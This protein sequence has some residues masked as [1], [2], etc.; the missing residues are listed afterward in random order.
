MET[1]RWDLLSAELPIGVRIT[2]RLAM[3]NRR[4]DVFIGIDAAG[5]RHVLIEIPAGEPQALIERASR[6]I[7]VQ[8]VSMK[9]ASDGSLCDFV[10]IV[11]IDASGHGALDLVATE[12]ADVLDSGAEPSRIEVVQNILARWRRFW[13]DAGPGLLSYQSQLGL[14]GELWF[15]SRWVGPSVGFARGV[16]VWRG[17]LGAR[18]DFEFAGAGFEV[19]TSARADGVHVVNGLEQLIE[20]ADGALFLLS[21]S[22]RDEATAEDS[23]PALVRALR[24]ALAHDFAHLS[25][26]DAVLYASGYRDEMEH[27]YKK[28]KF[29]VRAE[30]LYRVTAEFPRIV[31]ESFRDVLPPG[32]G[33]VT[34]ELDLECANSWLVARSPQAAQEVLKDFLR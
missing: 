9:I 30:R 27:E 8:V 19:K 15:L 4:R 24:V 6:G 33:N 21:V 22:V 12:I 5:R 1:I 10:D 28:V 34:Y 2:V 11:C 13:A 17:P 32:I 14:F 18:N 26:F 29:R 16:Q 23:L 7:E 25:D 31:P 3:P 20:P